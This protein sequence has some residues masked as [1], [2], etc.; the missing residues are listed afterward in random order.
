MSSTKQRQELAR[1]RKQQLKA[2]QAWTL[3]SNQADYIAHEWAHCG[4]F[5]IIPE[6]ESIAQGLRFRQDKTPVV[7]GNHFMSWRTT[8][9]LL[10]CYQE[11]SII[12]D[13]QGRITAADSLN[14]TPHAIQRLWERDGIGIRA[15]N[16]VSN[17][18]I[19]CLDE[20]L[21]LVRASA[22]TVLTEAG[23]YA[24]RTDLIVPYR[25]GALLGSIRLGEGTVTYTA[26]D[27][28]FNKHQKRFC[29]HTWVSPEQLHDS[30]RA[31]CEA[32]LGNMPVLA[33]D[34]MNKYDFRLEAVDIQ[35]LDKQF[36]N[37]IMQSAIR[38]ERMV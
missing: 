21:D 23:Q 36:R 28:K 25:G 18:G 38:A 15:A 34:L 35:Y 4:L 1:I 19:E 14:W 31:V 3:R 30:Q 17:L 6:E 10:A 13:E 5:D 7:F 2:Q 29:S 37:E 26:T 11:E 24:L 9:N 22:K 27:V 8:D 16:Y 33:A 12:K 20:Y 32:I